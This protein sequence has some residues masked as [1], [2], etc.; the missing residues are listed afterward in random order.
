MGKEISLDN[1]SEAYNKL[2]ETA[3][4]ANE[5]YEQVTK[6]LNRDIYP[7][8]KLQSEPG[9]PYDLRLI[10]FP[11]VLEMHYLSAY[12]PIKSQQ[13]IILNSFIDRLEFNNESTKIVVGRS[14]SSGEEALYVGW[15]IFP[16]TKREVYFVE[17]HGARYGDNKSWVLEGN[18]DS[19]LSP[20]SIGRT[21][22]NKDELNKNGPRILEKIDKKISLDEFA[23]V[24][25]EALNS[26]IIS[27]GI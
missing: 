2:S 17:R 1:L 16:S 18:L 11:E 12:E 15:R 23:D 24:Y 26:K 14:D 19:F 5:V 25:R 7:D 20:E 8:Y 27:S 10:E 4:Q 3:A 6:F 21:P 9:E 22:R 13:E